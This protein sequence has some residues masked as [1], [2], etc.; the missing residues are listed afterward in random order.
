MIES[1][2]DLHQTNV[3][4]NDIFA[5]CLKSARE[6]VSKELGYCSEGQIYCK[7]AQ[8]GAA[9]EYSVYE[10]RIYVAPPIDVNEFHYK[11][12]MT[13]LLIHE[14]AHESAS[15]QRM[16]IFSETL[17][18]SEKSNIIRVAIGMAVMG[19]H[20]N[21]QIRHGDFFEEAFAETV[22]ARWR[23]ASIS[24]YSDNADS[25][26]PT[27]DGE[28]LP[29]KYSSPSHGLD[30]H[31]SLGVSTVH[32][33]YAAYGIELLSDHSGVDLYE[34]MKQARQPDTEVTAKREIIKTFAPFSTCI[35]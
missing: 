9:G 28:Y 7:P 24:G 31:G 14:I 29:I 27:A 15:V 22:A 8:A 5:S 13:S 1:F 6:F 3:E 12:I 19:M 17:K 16:Y 26:L 33:A 32:S 11:T 21:T 4:T 30:E 34:L 25:L 2:D 23:S 20:A 18:E 35:P 10:D